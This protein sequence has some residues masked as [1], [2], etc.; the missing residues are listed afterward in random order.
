ME[1]I[2]LDLTTGGEIMFKSE[3]NVD[4]R[5]ETGSNACH[6]IRDKGHVPGVVY[7]QHTASRT[8]EID[9]REL[10]S[11]IRNN[12]TNVM[13]DLHFGGVEATVM[14]KDVQR[15]P[16]TREIM[17]VDF[18]EVSQNEAIHTMVPIKLVGKGKVESSLGVVQQQLREIAIECLPNNIP[19]SIEV[20]VSNLS[21]GHPMR[22]ADVEFGQ[23]LSI[24][25]DPKEIIAALAKAEKATEDS[26]GNE[27]L[28]SQVMDMPKDKEESK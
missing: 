23:E 15:N 28:L 1:I 11:I 13:L 24:L 20:D 5:S 21:P 2:L 14:L 22:V 27:D 4:L 10:D 8:L 25:N 9:R 19:S 16:I 3:M 17:H 26:E 7:G 6:R 18:L 12:G